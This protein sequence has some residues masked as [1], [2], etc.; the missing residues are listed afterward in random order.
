MND[1]TDQ[2][3]LQDYVEQRADAAFGELVRRHVDAVYSAA[4][5]LTGE[6]QSARD[7]TQAV[8]VI[9]A[10]KASSLAGHP[11]LSGWLHT[12]ARNQACKCI[13]SEVRRRSCEQ[14][15]ATMNEL[16]STDPETTWEH[17]APHLDEA[18]G[19]LSDAD[20]DAVMLRYFEKKSA[21]EMAGLLGI[22]E[23]AAQKRVG[24]AVDRLREL[25]SKRKVT[26]G[27]GGLVGLISANAVQSAPAGL[28]TIIFHAAI[29]GTAVTASTTI[30]AAKAIAMTTLQ[31]VLITATVAALAGTGIFE[32][33]QAAQLRDQNQALQQQEAPL[34]DTI[35]K[36]QE[37]NARLSNTVAQAHDQ[38][39]LSQ[40]QLNEL[41]KLRGQ[42]GQALTAVQELA[43]VRATAAQRNQIPDYFTNAMARGMAVAEQFRKK[44][45]RA[46][47]ARMQ[48]Q[49]HLTGD[50]ALSVS[51][52]LIGQIEASQQHMLQAMSG[53]TLPATAQTMAQNRKSDEAAIKD[54]LTP[55]QLAAYPDFVH[56]ET[57]LTADNS[58]KGE[59]TTMAGEMDLSPEQK[60][61]IH[62]VFYQYDLN[63]STATRMKDALARAGAS[64]N[65]S[66]AATLA[67][68]AGQTAL[69]DKLKLLGDILTPDQLAAYKQKQESL[70]DT[71]AN[72]LKMF[73]PATNG[74]TQAAP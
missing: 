9:L 30:I 47:V 25:F 4:I 1:L 59:V 15:A 61:K 27:A 46:K 12:T 68:Q 5:R 24:R 69:D 14:E 58:A 64:G 57:V 60:D 38:K 44:E 49:L 19:E 6:E 17:I 54:L 11:V 51:N 36:L 34:T 32:A 7:A 43:K 74:V 3:L 16:L 35:S 63:N 13:R 18:L 67:L 23:D 55:D 45:I 50:Q 52:I 39:V 42:S 62:A 29:A 71:Q 8:F 21:P 2:Q 37:E 22:S 72:A 20:R 73:M 26:V 33:R 28:A 56:S 53:G 66:D 48:D 65:M 70:L 10:Q 40:A 41:L 31:K